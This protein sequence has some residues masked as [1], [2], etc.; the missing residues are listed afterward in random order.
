[1]YVIVVTFTNTTE[2]LSLRQH[3]HCHGNEEGGSEPHANHNDSTRRIPGT[4]ILC[5]QGSL[6]VI[7]SV[8]NILCTAFQDL[9]LI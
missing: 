4:Y 3:T 5:P 7:N 9:K 2:I 6:N 8:Y 1:M